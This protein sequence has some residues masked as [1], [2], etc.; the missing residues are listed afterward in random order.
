MFDFLRVLNKSNIQ[1]GDFTP[2][3]EYL[4]D[5]KINYNQDKE[6]ERFVENKMPY[7]CMNYIN[8]MM[9][10][11][12]IVTTDVGQNQMWAAQTIQLKKGQKYLTSGG[13][14]PMGYAMPSAIGCAFANLSKTVYSVTGDGGFHMAIICFE[15][16]Y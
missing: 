1:T 2:W 11:G 13:L 9:K 5:L 6:V 8:R 14:A 3:K 10:E 16:N 4:K 7:H 12:D 15:F